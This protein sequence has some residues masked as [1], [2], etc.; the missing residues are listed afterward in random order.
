MSETPR[1]P[2]DPEQCRQLLLDLLHRNDDLR[3]QAEEQ[4]GLDALRRSLD[5]LQRVLDATAADYSQLKDQYDEAL[6]AL[7]LL[8]RYVYG[9]RRERHVDDPAQ[10]HLFDLDGI[11]IAIE[12]PAPAEPAA[13]EL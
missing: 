7:A 2:D 9:S 10:G 3:R 6:E 1:I 4:L 12:E 5:E 8:R 11:A 13:T